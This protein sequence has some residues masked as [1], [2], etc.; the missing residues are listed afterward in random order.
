MNQPVDERRGLPAQC[1]VGVD[2]GPTDG[3]GGD[4]QGDGY[5]L[6]GRPGGLAAQAAQRTD[7]EHIS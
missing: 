7:S 3:A 6:L 4:Q 1:A 2:L 5:D